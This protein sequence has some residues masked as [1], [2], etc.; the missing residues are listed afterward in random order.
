M[1]WWRSFIGF[2]SG[3]ASRQPGQQ[4]GTP[5]SYNQKS[6]T[7]VSVD[8][9]LQLSTVYACCK[10]I[11]ET[12]GA[13]PLVMY[14]K[15]ANG[16]K[17]VVTQHP[18]AMLFSGKVNKWQTPQEFFESLTWQKCL[19]GNNYAAI[20][21][22]DKKEIIALTPLMTSQTEVDLLPDG[23]IVYYYQESSERKV[24]AASNIWHNKLFGNGII[25]LNPLSFA[26]N[27]VG[28]AQGAENV[29]G[30]M[31]QN[32]GK[33]SGILTIDKILTEAQRNQ[34][35][36][37]FAELKEGVDDRLFVLE[38]DMKYATV[39]L[40][41][42]DI[43]LLQS[44][45]FQIEDLCRFFGVPSVLVNDTSATTVWGSG[46]QQIVQG[47]YKLGLRPY[48]TRYQSSMGANLLT[49][50]ERTKFSLEFD[51]EA[52]LQ[53][54]FSERVKTGK[55]AISGGMMTPNEWR[56]DE[57]YNPL[58]GGDTIY[59]QQQMT[60]MEQLEKIDRTKSSAPQ[61]AQA[62]AGQ[63]PI[64]NHIHLPE[65]R[66][67]DIHMPP[68]VVNYNP[69]I[70]VEAPQ[71]IVKNEVPAPVVNV[72]APNVQIKNEIKDIKV[73]SLPKRKTETKVEYNDKGDIKHTTQ[74][75]TDA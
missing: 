36:K 56:R 69:D 29:V 23:S 71:V 47:F 3:A 30:K 58:P 52:L 48:I 26:R 65:V 1:Q 7:P 75:E 17:V 59:M 39:S 73:T 35:K 67:P 46:I 68:P 25:G 45:R 27:S 62:H 72:A 53:P 32:G 54:E 38:A 10:L 19:L 60:P 18:L 49:A 51:L 9:A 28:I 2:L 64:N 6:A 70:N 31:Y 13:L 33:P 55:E 40:S 50:Q 34:I 22:N 24:F 15:K 66:I 42:Q 16:E 11:T 43:E 44:R 63:Q 20:Q 74:I 14:E 57:G 4:T 41:P 8:S 37:N 5:G 61:G 12:I 21:R